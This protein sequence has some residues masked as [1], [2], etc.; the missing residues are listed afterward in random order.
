MHLKQ[1]YWSGQI[2]TEHKTEDKKEQPEEDYFANVV[3]SENKIQQSEDDYWA[4]VVTNENKIEQS[5]DDYWAN[6]V[7]NEQH[8]V[9]IIDG[10]EIRIN[11]ID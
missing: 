11:E 9:S 3:T 7:T 5:E 4:D 1:D 6:V 10:H 2:T 8:L